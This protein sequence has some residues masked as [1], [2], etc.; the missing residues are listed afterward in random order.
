MNKYG[1]AILSAL[2]LVLML[3]F[4]GYAAGQLMQMADVAGF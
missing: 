1:S 2:L 3:L 4:F